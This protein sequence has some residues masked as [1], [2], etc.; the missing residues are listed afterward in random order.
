MSLLNKI[1][2]KKV[3]EKDILSF[4]VDKALKELLD[5]V[6]EA[7]PVDKKPS[8]SSLCREAFKLGL[9]QVIQ[10]GGLDDEYRQRLHDLV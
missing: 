5:D 7:L 2:K 10:E 6:L 1:R 3:P 8:R 4:Q 9:E